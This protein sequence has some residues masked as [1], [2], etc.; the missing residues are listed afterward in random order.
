MENINSINERISS[1]KR[2]I[3]IIEWDMSN[4]KN[5]DVKSRKERVLQKCR[6]ELQQLMQSRSL[7]D[8]GDQ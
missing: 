7:I 4:I 2:D 8:E 3:S 5:N 6:E 1:L